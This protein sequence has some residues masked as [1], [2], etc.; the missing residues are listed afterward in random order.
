MSEYQWVEFRAVDAPL[1]DAALEFMHDQSTRAEIDRWRFTN[2]YH[3]G[4]FRGD[5][6]EMMRRGYDVHVHYANYGIRRVC[7]RIPDGFGHSD[8][9]ESYLLDYEIDWDPDDEGD[10]GVLTLEPEGDAGTW[11]WM[12]DVESLA[13][14]LTPLR[15]MIIAGDFRP[16]Y[17]AH[18]AFNY[19]D[20]A[21]EPP[22]PSGLGDQ[23]HALD[24]LCEFYEI[25]PDLVSVAA[26]ASPQLKPSTSANVVIESWLKQ[27]SKADLINDL[28]N[29]LRDPTRHPM[30]LLRKIRTESANPVVVQ[31]GT[32]AIEELHRRAREIDAQRELERKA[33]AAKEAERRRIE[34]EQALQEKLDQIAEN[35]EKCIARI[36]AAITERNRP[37]YERAAEELSLLAKACGDQMAIAKAESIRA[38]YP[39]RSAL[40]SELKRAGF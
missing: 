14:D 40:S 28:G 12:E 37:A 15:E 38:E 17:I 1:D 34:A 22:V 33:A 16:L 19:D 31:S 4:E 7:L 9:I 13:S 39:S 29:C 10:G 36:D 21:M 23:H 35:P 32:R 2:E 24:R 20:E 6:Y 8:E 27:Q 30:Q 18:V 26:E 11:D 3:W 25:S 5:V